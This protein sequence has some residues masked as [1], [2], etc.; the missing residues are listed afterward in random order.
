LQTRS[1][2]D[3]DKKHPLSL[4]TQLQFNNYYDYVSLYNIAA[5]K[6]NVELS[7]KALFNMKT[8]HDYC[9]MIMKKRIAMFQKTK[10]SK[11]M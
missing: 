4:S 6:Y 3:T 5:S 11:V 1:L 8:L 9:D 2:V 10:A 7:Q